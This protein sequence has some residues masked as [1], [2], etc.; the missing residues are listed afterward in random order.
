MPSLKDRTNETHMNNQGYLMTIVKYNNTHDII[1]EFN[2]ERKTCVNSDYSSF[3]KGKVKN[4]YNKTMYGLGYIGDTTTINEN[5]DRKHSYYVWKRMMRRC[6]DNNF[7][8]ENPSYKDCYV[9]DEW[10]CYA[11]FEKWYNENYYTIKDIVIALDK[12]IICKGNKCYCP[13][14]CIFVPQEINNLFETKK[15]IKNLTLPTGISVKDKYYY[16]HSCSHYVG[17]YKDIDSAKI[18][19]KNFKEQHIKDI[20]NKYKD[21]IPLKLYN[22]LYNYEVSN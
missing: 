11:N 18:A 10:L 6:Y 21:L 16:V 7:H 4:P 12:D 19:Y 8:K 2:D 1:V 13:S 14:K 9:C 5:G 15:K 3:I 22:T 20:A 17:V